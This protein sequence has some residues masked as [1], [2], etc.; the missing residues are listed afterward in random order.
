MATLV[1]IREQ[2]KATLE[3][4]GL[5]CYAQKPPDIQPPCVIVRPESGEFDGAMGRG[6]DKYTVELDVYCSSASDRAAQNSLDDYVSGYG[7]KSIRQ[8]IFNDPTLRTDPNR[9]VAGVATMT[10]YVSGFSGYGPD[11]ES[12]GQ[13]WHAVVTVE[14]L[15]RGDS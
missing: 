14:V 11:Q 2:I 1:Q 12:G 8:A 3:Q 10:A 7:A 13:Y 9:N 15:T 4:V 5:R 6:S